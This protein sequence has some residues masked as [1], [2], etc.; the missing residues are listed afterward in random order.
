MDNELTTGQKKGELI[1]N[2]KPV[3][4]LAMFVGIADGLLTPVN[5]KWHT[6]KPKDKSLL[7]DKRVTQ[8]VRLLL[9]YSNCLNMASTISL[10]VNHLIC[11]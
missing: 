3:L 8:F 2:S 1:Y 11:Y 10:I 7:K 9:L 5:K 4:D 6:L